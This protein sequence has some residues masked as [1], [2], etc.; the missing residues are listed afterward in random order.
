MFD[1][2]TRFAGGIRD[3]K[4]VERLEPIA[5]SINVSLAPVQELRSA[6]FK[7]GRRP[8]RLLALQFLDAGKDQL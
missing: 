4:S 7:V 8:I 3:V 5:E 2:D 1:G 6:D